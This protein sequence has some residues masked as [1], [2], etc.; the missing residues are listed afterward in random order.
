MGRANSSFL[1]VKKKSVCPSFCIQEL[2]D[3]NDELL[4]GSLDTAL[5]G[6]G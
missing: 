1:K 3:G 5:A 4:A 6:S 2:G